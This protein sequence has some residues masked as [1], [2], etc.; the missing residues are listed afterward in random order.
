MT[1]LKI[2]L[3]V[4]IAILESGCTSLVKKARPKITLCTVD[5]PRLELVCSDGGKPFRL[6]FEFADKYIAVT[7]S[8]WESIQNYI[9]YLE[10]NQRAK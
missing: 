5:Q 3:I 10:H 9:D 7:P 1:P 2:W 4:L 8:A 6:Q